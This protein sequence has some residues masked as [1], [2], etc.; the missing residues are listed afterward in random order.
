MNQDQINS[1][2][3]Q[4]NN[5]QAQIDSLTATK[6][7]VDAAIKVLTDGY[8][9]DQAAIDAAITAAKDAAKAALS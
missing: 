3:G 8:Q 7:G 6:A 1:L 5:L 4:S 2:Q 9:T